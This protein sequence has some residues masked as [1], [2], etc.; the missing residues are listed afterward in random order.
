[1][2]SW[3]ILEKKV[4]QYSEYIWDRTAKA[5]RIEGV[6]FDS[7][8]HLQNNEIVII[9]ITQ[10]NSLTKIREDVAKIQSVTMTLISKFVM[11]RPYIICEFEPTPGMR[12]V[13]KE[14]NISV[15]SFKEFQRMYFDFSSY[16][17]V[18]DKKQFGSA[19]DPISGRKDEST[20]VP[21]KYLEKLTNRELSIEDIAQNI[22]RVNRIVLT[23]DYGT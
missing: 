4:R 19:I 3:E 14:K 12:D 11:P 10:N 9:E 13:G 15:L 21:V 17:N 18:R 20:Y 22:T 6:N 2:I 16:K 7:V 1:M 5:E 23:G 8:L